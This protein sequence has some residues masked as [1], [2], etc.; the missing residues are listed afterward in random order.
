MLVPF[1]SDCHR[2]RN[3]WD[4]HSLSYS[5]SNSAV[6]RLII[7]LERERMEIWKERRQRFGRG[8]DRDLE[9]ERM[10]RTMREQ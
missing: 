2:V 7:D 8:E 3:G 9:G 10:E 6:I 5:V 1:N 4:F